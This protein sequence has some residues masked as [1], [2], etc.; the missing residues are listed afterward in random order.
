VFYIPSKE[1]SDAVRAVEARRVVAYGQA[2]AA[3]V[4]E[5]PEVQGSVLDYVRR[6]GAAMG[7][8]M[9]EFQA[10]WFDLRDDPISRFAFPL[11]T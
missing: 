2:P 8:R 5:E 6:Y 4:N 9:Y 10:R 7:M 1:W 11:L 3:E